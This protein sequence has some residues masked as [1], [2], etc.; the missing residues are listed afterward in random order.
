MVP[1]LYTATLYVLKYI[2]PTFYDCR[3]YGTPPYP[4]IYPPVGKVCFSWKNMRVYNVLLTLFFSTFFHQ[5]GAL[6]LAIAPTQTLS[7]TQHC[8]KKKFRY[9]KT[10]PQKNCLIFSTLMLTFWCV[11]KM[12]HFLDPILK[13]YTYFGGA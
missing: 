5:R 13:K 4:N 2:F 10:F 8:K 1:T 6:Q 7:L 9:Q 12:F 3:T 11:S